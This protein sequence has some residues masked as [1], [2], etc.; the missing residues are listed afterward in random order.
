MPH[1]CYPNDRELGYSLPSTYIATVI[2][3]SCISMTRKLSRS[4]IN[5]DMNKRKF[6]EQATAIDI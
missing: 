2:F 6:W 4:Q 5:E 3:I 1:G